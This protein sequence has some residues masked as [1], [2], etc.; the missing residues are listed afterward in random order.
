[1]IS[2]YVRDDACTDSGVNYPRPRGKGRS[3]EA[4][5]GLKRSG[6]DLRGAISDL[7]RRSRGCIANDTSRGLCIIGTNFVWIFAPDN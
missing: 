7:D 5:E 2:K 6:R 3:Q 4:E 1:M